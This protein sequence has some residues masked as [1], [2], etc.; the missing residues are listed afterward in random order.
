M[1][2][3]IF[4]DRAR[5]ISQPRSLSLLRVANA[6]LVKAALLCALAP[7]AIF[8]ICLQPPAALA[9]L[10]GVALIAFLILSSQTGGALLAAPLDPPL[11]AG[12]LAASL[13]LCLLG[14]EYHVFFSTWDWFTR[15]AV[16][17]DLVNNKYP[18]L[19][20]YQGADFILR[21]PL[22]MY[23]FPAAVGWGFGLKAAHLALLL[24][25]SFLFGAI[26]YLV[27][28]LASGPKLR[29]LALFVMSGPVDAIPH[30]FES[31]LFQENGQFVIQPHFMNWNWLAW[32]WAQL[33]QIFWAPNHAFSGWMTAT[34][35]LL[36]IRREIDIALL[37]L[38]SI[39][40][41]FWSPLV[42]I[43]AA[44][45]LLARGF[46][47]LSP[48]LLRPRTALA[49]FAGVLLLPLLVYLSLDAAVLSRNWLFE[50]KGFFVWYPL[51]LVFSLPQVWLLAFSR[52]A[53]PQWLKPT[54]ALVGAVLILFPLY[55]IGATADDNDMA[56]RG[57]L[58]PMFLL[59]FI[60]AER[61]PLLVEGR[62]PRALL[63][64]AIIFVSAITGLM[65]IRRALSDPTY[66]INDCNL[67]T[68]TDKINKGFPAP[69]Y[70][71]H[72]EQAPGWLLSAEGRRLEIEKR[73]CWPGFAPL[74]GE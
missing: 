74:A 17:A 60:F 67:L 49:L 21:A 26:L 51:A 48:E 64:T 4:W 70:L 16:L 45:L 8:A 44:P 10:A 32:Y 35:L 30:I 56:M 12:C 3:D 25:N 11:L 6:Q 57:M 47:S 22:G 46:G 41:L 39:A 59:G 14:G 24:Q 40:L 5:P 71:A 23:M 55:R 15:D 66:E 68:A 27:A 69:N 38:S 54:F 20:H 43:G 28:S 2:E 1:S 61:A 34:L 19:Y 36:N 13:L 33:P 58:V 7:I 37:A 42:M 72:V 31:W 52:D 50:Q 63:T 62:R 53:I 65:E 18:V 73:Q 29:F 9:L